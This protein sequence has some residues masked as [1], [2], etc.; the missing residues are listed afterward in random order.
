MS[1]S[2]NERVFTDAKLKDIRDVAKKAGI[3]TK[4]IK[5]LLGIYLQQTGVNTD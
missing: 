3:S 5:L 2:Y 4:I 1:L